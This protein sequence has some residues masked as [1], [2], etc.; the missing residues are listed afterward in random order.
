VIELIASIRTVDA[1]LLN[2]KYCYAIVLRPSS[3]NQEVQTTVGAEEGYRLVIIILRDATASK[4]A[5]DESGR[6]GNRKRWKGLLMPQ[7][8]IPVQTRMET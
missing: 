1:G 8:R 4:K 3:G 2:G 6:K 7:V 5:D